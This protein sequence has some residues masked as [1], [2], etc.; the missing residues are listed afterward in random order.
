MQ[1]KE[2]R[3]DQQPNEYLE[4]KFHLTV[5]IINNNIMFNIDITIIS[6]WQSCYIC[7]DVTRINKKKK[8]KNM[9]SNVRD[10]RIIVCRDRFLN[11]GY[12]RRVRYFR[13]EQAPI[14]RR[15]ML[16][17]IDQSLSHAYQIRVSRLE[18]RNCNFSS[19]HFRL[20]V[21]LFVTKS[22]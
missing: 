20:V 22:R 11:Y 19:D 4:T 21:R 10:S 1:N 6:S 5:Y 15:V 14:G 2:A 3:F 18:D 13:L 8:K 9:T 16:F 7:Y 12:S 17:W